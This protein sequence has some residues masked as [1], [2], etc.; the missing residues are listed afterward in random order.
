MANPN[1]SYTNVITSTWE[2]R[3][4]FLADNITTSNI[5]LA[6]F[7]RK[8]RVRPISGGNKIIEPIL[9]TGATATWYTGGE[10]LST[11]DTDVLTAAE[12]TIKE[13]AAPCTMTGI[14][15]AQ[16]SGSEQFIDLLEAKMQAAEASMAN[17]INTGIWS[18]GTE[19]SGKTLVGLRAIVADDGTG[20]IGG[21]AQS[22]HSWWGNNFYNGDTVTAAN[23][24]EQL[25]AE[26]A[27]VARGGDTPDICLMGST[28]WGFYMSQLQGLQ[29]FVRSDSAVQ[30]FNATKYLTMD[31][32]LDTTCPTATNA[33]LLNS[34]FLSFRPHR[35]FN[36]KPSPTVR[37]ADADAE[38]THLLFKG[39]LTVSNRARQG[40]IVG[41]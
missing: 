39:A 30:G 34:K 7:K 29:Q 33:Y 19:F 4:S 12:F 11:A 37:A 24:R 27:E 8:G 13:I 10:S 21:I 6:E 38:V 28:F 35:D 17:A 32:Y 22:A 20:T 16:N 3:S 31:C 9:H 36:M 25:N 2:N 15:M 40:V 23:V 41:A 5:A 18:L 1:S 14:E 26:Y